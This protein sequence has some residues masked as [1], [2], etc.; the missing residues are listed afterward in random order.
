M[1]LNF[2]FFTIKIERNHVQPEQRLAAYARTRY[3]EERAEA[4]AFEAAQHVSRI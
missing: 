2:L 3:L 1:V 4:H